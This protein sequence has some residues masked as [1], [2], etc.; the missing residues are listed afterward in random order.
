MCAH[1]GN[2][3]CRPQAN[4][5]DMCGVPLR[6]ASVAIGAPVYAVLGRSDAAG[7]MMF[8]EAHSQQDVVLEWL[9]ELTE[10]GSLPVSTCREYYIALLEAAADNPKG[11]RR[12]RHV[13]S[14]MYYLRWHADTRTWTGGDELAELPPTID[15]DVS[16]IQRIGARA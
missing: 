10:G 5:C 15:V 14:T 11:P 6:H 16:K 7:W 9:R 8:T 2:T 3:E 4:F 13:V 12:R 1:C